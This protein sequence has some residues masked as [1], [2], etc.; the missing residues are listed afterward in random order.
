MNI[1]GMEYTDFDEPWRDLLVKHREEVSE[2]A[3][4][5]ARGGESPEEGAETD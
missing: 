5:E 1:A 3:C 4:F 2:E